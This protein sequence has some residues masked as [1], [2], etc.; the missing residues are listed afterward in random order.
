[1]KSKSWVWKYGHREGDK[2]YCDLCNDETNNEFSCR[3]GT[4]GS[5]SRHLQGIHGLSSNQSDDQED[6]SSRKR[7]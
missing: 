7:K 3:G 5:L 1:M 2:A 4:T 6:L